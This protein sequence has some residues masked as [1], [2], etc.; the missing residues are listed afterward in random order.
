ML[1]LQTLG[2]CLMPLSS[3][4]SQ[5]ST[6]RDVTTYAMSVKG[7]TVPEHVPGQY[8]RKASMSPESALGPA[9]ETAAALLR[10]NLLFCCVHLP[11]F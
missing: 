2:P 3:L 1:L 4:Q 7:H 8:L 6:I 5:C 10:E 11:C 9:Q